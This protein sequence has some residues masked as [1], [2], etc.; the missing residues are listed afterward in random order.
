MSAKTIAARLPE[1]DV[2]KKL[3]QSL[4]MLDAIMSREW[5]Y[6]YYSFNSKWADGEQMASMRDGSGDG[7]YILFNS[8][9]AF[10]KGFAHESPMSP[11]NKDQEQVWPGVLDEV[12]SEFAAYLTEPAFSM[13]DTTFCLWRRHADSE[14]QSGNI[15]YPADDDPDGAEDLLSMLTGSPSD[16]QQFAESYYE[17]TLP[18]STIEHIYQQRSLTDEVVAQLNPETDLAALKDDIEEIGYPAW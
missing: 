18:L 15:E 5:E 2:L 9:G 7:Y 8:Q 13:H 16:Y 14:W 6:R 1:V 4:A 17:V 11:W 12:P 3:C 10:L